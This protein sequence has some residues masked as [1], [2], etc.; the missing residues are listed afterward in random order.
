MK[1][2]LKIL[3]AVSVVISL[4]IT[5]LFLLTLFAWISGGGNVLLPGLGLVIT[6]GAVVIFLLFVLILSLSIT[7]L[8]YQVIFRKTLR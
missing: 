1:I 6:M 8:L 2:L 5:I 7:Y 4:I 3:F